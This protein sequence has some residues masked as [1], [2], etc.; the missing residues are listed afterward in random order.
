MTPHG[1]S[2]T[3]KMIR[4]L[5]AEVLRTPER[6]RDDENDARTSPLTREKITHSSSPLT[7]A[8]DAARDGPT[9]KHV[10]DDEDEDVVSRFER[11]VMALER[12]ADA[13][14][15]ALERD[16]FDAERATRALASLNRERVVAEASRRAVVDAEDARRLREALR[17]KERAIESL[18]GSLASTRET[19]EGRLRAEEERSRASEE[20][21]A[22]C[23]SEME[24]V[25]ERVRALESKNEIRE[26]KLAMQE[27]TIE[28]LRREVEAKRSFDSEV[29][30]RARALEIDRLEQRVK[31]SEERAAAAEGKLEAYLVERISLV[32]EVETLR[33]QVSRM[34][35]QEE[36]DEAFRL[37]IE[38]AAESKIAADRLLQE[39]ARTRM[40]LAEV[41]AQI[42]EM[43]VRGAGGKLLDA[44]YVSPL[45]PQP[46]REDVSAELER[47]KRDAEA[48]ISARRRE[49]DRIQTDISRDNARLRR[50]LA[51]VRGKLGEKLS[52]SPSGAASRAVGSPRSDSPWAADFS[53]PPKRVGKPTDAVSRGGSPSN[54]ADSFIEI[55]PA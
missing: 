19:Y 39:E 25:S 43:T 9:E 13:Y 26:H 5:A 29:H 4:E 37:R 10:V 34:P 30:D 54:S 32:R 45:A 48:E 11:R 41:F 49:F 46:T 18:T 2:P 24:A 47:I 21:E 12:T 36:Q 27:E 28:R 6:V 7:S 38:R 22:R 40:E 52:G 23:R 15:D 44:A 55:A 50:E 20:R 42:R 35:S 1:T 3:S 8:F 31:A 14:D 16:E 53:F 17:A 33:E 51:D